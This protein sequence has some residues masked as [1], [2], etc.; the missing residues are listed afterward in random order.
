MHICTTEMHI[1]IT[2]MHIF[3]TEMHIFGE[4]P[5]LPKNKSYNSES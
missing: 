5:I 1:F 2:E 3:I 4:N